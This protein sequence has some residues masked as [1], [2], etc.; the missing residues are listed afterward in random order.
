MV[1]FAFI[2]RVYMFMAQEAE[3]GATQRREIALT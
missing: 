2:G 1:S 3:N